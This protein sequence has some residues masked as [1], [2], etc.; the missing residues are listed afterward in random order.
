MGI[1]DEL[2]N[3]DRKVDGNL[4]RL[5]FQTH[6]AASLREELV[7][8]SRKDSIREAIAFHLDATREDCARLIPP[9]SSDVEY[10]EVCVA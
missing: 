1:D 6:P 2:R 4:S 8:E 3:R 9:A 7:E 5:T 10:V